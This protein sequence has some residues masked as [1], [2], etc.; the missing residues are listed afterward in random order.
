[1]QG[2]ARSPQQLSKRFG[3][4]TP[5]RTLKLSDI[6]TFKDG[7]VFERYSIPLR[8]DAIHRPRLSF[9]ESRHAAGRMREDAVYR[10]SHTTHTADNLQELLRAIPEIV[11]E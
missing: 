6:L 1:V 9:R 11:G 5:R 4:C 3:S 10:I 8:V 2:A 7:Q